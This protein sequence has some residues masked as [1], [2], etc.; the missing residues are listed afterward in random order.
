MN[1]PFLRW[2]GGKRWLSAELAPI[3]KARL[4]QGRYFEPFLGSGAMFF[5]VAPQKAFLSDLNNNLI[6]TFQC[7]AYKHDEVI[8][9]LSRL[10]PDKDTYYHIRNS[11][12]DNEIDKAVRLIYLNRNCWGGLYRENFKGEFNVPYGGGTRNHLRI[13]SD[14]TIKIASDLLFRPGIQFSTCDFEAS[15]RKAKKGDIIYCDPTYSV[16]TRDHFDRYGALIFS[17]DDQI[18]LAKAAS[19]AMSKGVLVVISNAASPNLKR[20]FPLAS[21]IEVSRRHGLGNSGKEHA[22]KELLFVL[23]P[24]MRV[25]EWK[26]LGKLYLPKDTITKTA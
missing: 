20:Q 7:V 13:C 1:T 17:W 12:P 3:L 25:E 8:S 14:G 18:R 22:N 16:V 2:A 9:R 6:T 5:T 24:E 19:K 15:M 26:P 4:G 10:S 11:T 23:D 21:I